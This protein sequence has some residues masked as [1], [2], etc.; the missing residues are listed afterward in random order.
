MIKLICQ[1]KRLGKAS[2]VNLFLQ[3]SQ[4]EILILSSADVLLTDKTLEYIIKPF[5][6]PEVGIVGSHPVPLNDPKTYFGF[7]AHLLWK[8]HHAIAL[9]TP[10]MGEFI[11]FRK[12]FKRIPAISGVDEANIEA[13]I[14]GQGYKA[15]Y[16]PNCIIYNKGA[17]NLKDFITRRR[18]IFAGHL[19][20][21]HEYRYEVSTISPSRILLILLKNIEFSWRFIIWTPAVALMEIYSRFLG[22]LDYK[23]KIEFQPIWEIAKSTKQL[24]QIGK[25]ND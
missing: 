23:S 12:L 3:E 8:L 17:E 7:S 1:K 15:V 20:T 10:K 21:K 22:F 9:S 2:A 5:K 25:L 16:E 18:Y 24:P 14:R 6:D 11:A 13:L 4:E 19:A